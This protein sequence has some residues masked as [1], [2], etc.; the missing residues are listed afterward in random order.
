MTG[1]IRDNLLQLETFIFD[2]DGVI[3]RGGEL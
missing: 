1:S 3:W 2:C